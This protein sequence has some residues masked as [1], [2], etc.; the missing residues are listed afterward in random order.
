MRTFVAILLM[1]LVG[2][3]YSQQSGLE[4]LLQKKFNTQTKREG[5]WVYQPDN[6]AIT[7]LKTPLINAR[8]PH[9][10]LYR[11][12]L[13]NYT[14]GQP[15]TASR[16]IMYDTVKNKITLVEPLHNGTLSKPFLH[17]FLSQRFQAKEQLQ[18]FIAELSAAVALG[19][20]YKFELADYS[21]AGVT[22]TLT[23]VA[24]NTTA[25]STIR[26]KN[27]KLWNTAQLMLR[28]AV[29]TQMVAADPIT[30]TLESAR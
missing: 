24:N 30:G 8:Y 9:A 19:P 22:Y 2:G 16:V 20:A 5:R 15:T 28:G 10:L 1:C 29:I 25:T 21:D 17:Q 6:S 3:G 26:Y 11:V 7:P 23:T 18:A 27:R 4:S 13:T 14:N 12:T